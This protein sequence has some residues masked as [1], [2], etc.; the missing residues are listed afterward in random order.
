M[1][2]L[3]AAGHHRT[4]TRRNSQTKNIISFTVK[5]RIG[6]DFPRTL[7]HFDLSRHGVAPEAL[8][9]AHVNGLQVPFQTSA[10]RGT[11]A[12][13]ISLPPYSEVTVEFGLEGREPESSTGRRTRL[14]NDGLLLQTATGAVC[15]PASGAKTFDPPAD[16]LSIPA[17]IAFLV[18]KDGTRM[19][20]GVIDT[21]ERIVSLNCDIVEDGPLW[22]TV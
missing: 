16:S 9:S 1:L 20:R 15:L 17:P 14:S 11:A 3:N 4:T 8:R 5:E 10:S 21:Y 6:A 19:G 13:F 18:R 12:V 7:C 22:T 2:R